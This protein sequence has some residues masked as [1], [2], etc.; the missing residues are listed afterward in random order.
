MFDIIARAV[1]HPIDYSGVLQSRVITLKEH[2]QESELIHSFLFTYA[3]PTDWKAGQHAVFTLPGMHV[4]GKTWRPFSVASAPHEGVIQIGTTIPPE[5]S[6]FKD[7][8][9]SL[10]P[11]D[12][13]HMYGPFGEFHIRPHMKRIVGVAGGIGITPFRSLI[14]DATHRKLPIPITLIY[15]TKDEHTYRNDLETLMSQNPHLTIHFVQNPD[16]V[17]L[18]LAS[19]IDEHKNT[20]HYFVS[21]SPGMIA[22]IQKNCHAQGVHKIVNDP[23]KGY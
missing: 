12:E 13:I 11:G 22:A 21:G 18:A 4:S 3:Q 19:A 6:D 8:L 10:V 16:E 2:R 1:R 20:A 17:N 7:K 9:L 5:H 14:A 15:A 23:F